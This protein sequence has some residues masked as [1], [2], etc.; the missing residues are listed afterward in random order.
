M[1]KFCRFTGGYRW[2]S[3]TLGGMGWFPGLGVEGFAERAL[4]CAVSHSYLFSMSNCF[5][6]D[7]LKFYRSLCFKPLWL[8]VYVLN[9]ELC[10]GSPF[11][12]SDSCYTFQVESQ[13][14]I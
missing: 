14:D 2:R 9:G 1:F 8:P 4:R 13:E 5:C 11:T 6:S 7:L 10:C 3:V 12:L